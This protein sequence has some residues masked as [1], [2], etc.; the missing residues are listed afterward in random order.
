[1]A[2]KFGQKRRRRSPRHHVLVHTAGNDPSSLLN[3]HDAR[4]RSLCWNVLRL[5]HLYPP[6]TQIKRTLFFA[7]QALL[8]G[9]RGWTRRAYLLN[10]GG[11]QHIPVLA[12]E[13]TSHF[14]IFSSP[15]CAEPR[16]VLGYTF[17]FFSLP[18][19]AQWNWDGPNNCYFLHRLLRPVVSRDGL[20]K[21][22][23]AQAEAVF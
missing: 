17:P 8:P 11:F 13:S 10:R 15:S 19:G 2:P 7:T 20:E 21:G 12:R 14:G 3:L 9:P 1:M 4:C 22:K 5:E 16:L 23:H 6:L 18:R